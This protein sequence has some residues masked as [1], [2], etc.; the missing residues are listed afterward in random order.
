M[1]WKV[2]TSDGPDQ[3]RKE[4]HFT[5]DIRL[6][7]IVNG[8]WEFYAAGNKLIT[9]KNNEFEDSFD[10]DETIEAN[11]ITFWAPSEEIFMLAFVEQGNQI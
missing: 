6:C 10:I 4:H 8:T 1:V 9:Y 3:R 2:L 5:S 11:K 7:E